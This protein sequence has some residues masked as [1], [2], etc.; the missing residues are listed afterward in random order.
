MLNPKLIYVQNFDK[1]T[2]RVKVKECPSLND[3]GAIAPTDIRQDKMASL[4]LIVCVN[5]Q[6]Q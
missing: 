5:T 2:R 1:Q 6:L 4:F 3:R